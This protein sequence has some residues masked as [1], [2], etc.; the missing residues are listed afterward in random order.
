MDYWYMCDEAAIATFL[1]RFHP[2]QSGSG[3]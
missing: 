1:A 3:V 2:S